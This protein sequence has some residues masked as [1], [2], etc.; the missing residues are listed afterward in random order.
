MNW[1]ALF[2]S[3]SGITKEGK[4]FAKTMLVCA[5]VWVLLSLLLFTVGLQEITMFERSWV[6]PKF[7]VFSSF[8]SQFFQNIK[9]NL[10]PEDVDLIVTDPVSAF[11]AQVMIAFSG[12]LVLGFP[13]F[14]YKALRFLFPALR[15]GEKMS[16]VKILLP[17]LLLF[18]GGLAFAYFFLIPPTFRI[19]YSFATAIEAATYFTARSFVLLTLGFSVGVG[20][21]FLTPILMAVL[22]RFGVVDAESWLRNWRYAV[23]G[24]LVLAAFITPGTSGI[25]MIF[26]VVPLILLYF[27]GYLLSKESFL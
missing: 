19:L 2:S 21:M 8:S 10:L 11:L 7:S 22:A 5:G 15:R 16:L 18:G 14:L 13:F 23:M 4:I 3:Q 6:V 25:T 17:S 27:L 1:E 26:L 12:G 9:N 24:F 20:I